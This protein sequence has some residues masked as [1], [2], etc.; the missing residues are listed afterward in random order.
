MGGFEATVATGLGEAA[1]F[2]TLPWVSKQLSEK[3]GYLPHPGTLNLQLTAEQAALW[4]KSCAELSGVTIDP[5]EGFCEARCYPVKVNGR[6]LAHIVKPLVPDYPKEKVELIS[7][8]KFRSLLGLADGELLHLEPLPHSYIPNDVTPF[9]ALLF[10]LEGTLV[11]F[12]WK[13]PEAE[14]ELRHAIEQ[15]GLPPKS[16]QGLDY[17]TLRRHA[18][19]KIGMGIS[20]REKVDALLNPIYDRYDSDACSRWSLREGVKELLSK[21]ETHGIACALVSNIGRKS[22][23]ELLKKFGLADRFCAVVTRDEVAYMKPDGEG[24]LRALVE[25]GRSGTDA[26][27][28]GDSLSDLMAARDAEISVALITGGETLQR[29]LGS[30]RPD[31]LVTSLA[32]IADLALW[33]RA[34][35]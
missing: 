26:L 13:L 17:A 29:P 16:L 30:W 33:S 35:S 11:D 14:E 9:D 3:L 23:E 27:M 7:P 6:V 4:E 21:L 18:Y 2:I 1:G 5:A 12:Q 20:S 28:V 22:V 15:L 34:S 32:Q 24:I 19:S 10:D 31:Y 25:L 8:H